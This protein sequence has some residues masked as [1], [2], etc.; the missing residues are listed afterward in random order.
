MVKGLFSTT[1]V[2]FALS[3]HVEAGGYPNMEIAKQHREMLMLKRNVLNLAEGLNGE[4]AAERITRG[5][6]E[7]INRINEDNRL[8]TNFDWCK[9]GQ[10]TCTPSWNQ[11]IPV[12]CGSCYLHAS[13]STAQD[14]ITIRSRGRRAPV[15]LSRQTYLNCGMQLGFSYGCGGGE[16]EEVYEYMK[17]HG[18]PEEG[19]QIYTAKD[20]NTTHG[21]MNHCAKEEIC[22]NCMSGKTPECW[23]IEKPILWH[24]TGYGEVPS[25]NVRAIM[26]EVYQHGPVVCGLASYDDF[27]YNYR[28][29][30][31]MEGRDKKE[32]NHDVEI[33]GWGTSKEGQDYWTI[34]NSWG[35]FW[36]E[37]GFFK[38]PRGVN[39]MMIEAACAYVDVDT[40]MADAVDEGRLAGSMYGIVQGE[41][42]N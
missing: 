31:W 18:I 11:H 20:H 39:H 13:L 6:P 5:R 27:D 12:Y 8:P 15:M 38:I 9:N 14:R 30:I 24:S 16:P 10:N 28:G 3:A 41:K 29:G 37:E 22:H 34:R 26:E 32:M 2:L 17:Q 7:P 23:A 25:K 21:N 19:C 42:I 35:T 1:A 33:V 40:K 36:G 4:S